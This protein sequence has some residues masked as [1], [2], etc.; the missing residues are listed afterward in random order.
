MRPKMIKLALAAALPIC[1]GQVALAG[2]PTVPNQPATPPPAQIA[3]AIAQ[4]AAAGYIVSTTPT[5]DYLV[6]APSGATYGPFSSSFVASVL[7]SIAG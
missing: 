3:A 5:G 6:T 1:L 7:A 2:G 4:A